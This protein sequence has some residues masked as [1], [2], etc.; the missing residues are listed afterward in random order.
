MYSHN[1]VAA[2]TKAAPHPGFTQYPE[3]SLFSWLEAYS[4]PSMIEWM[5]RQ[6][7]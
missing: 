1:T 3:V 5:L 6:L 4:D 7:K 2:L